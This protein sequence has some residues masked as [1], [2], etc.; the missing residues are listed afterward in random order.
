M[1]LTISDNS[2][3][4]VVTKLEKSAIYQKSLTKKLSEVAFTLPDVK[5]GSVIE[6][7]YSDSKESIAS[8]DDWYF[9]DDIPTRLS[10]YKILVPSIFKFVNQVMA[11]QKVEQLKS[12]RHESIPTS[13]GIITY[14]SEEKTYIVRNV[15]ALRD[16]PYMGA[17]KDYL[18][19]VVFQLSQIVYGNGQVDEIM[20]TWPKLTEE[21]L[22]MEDFGLQ[23]KKNIPR[24]KGLDDS[25]KLVKND[26][27]KM[28]LVHDYVR[29]NMNWNG[30]ESIYSWDG[31]KSAWDKKSGSNGEI[32]LILI[33]L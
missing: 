19:R 27:E 21:L 31:I 6:Y 12:V 8:L 11:Y 26:Y 15:P 25:L 33:N 24:T 16:E 3:N 29:R 9:Q 32:N 18:Q 22:A 7:K 13:G 20:S 4:V 10:V 17:A 23:L 14:D 5:V 30:A 2:G 28:V 1:L